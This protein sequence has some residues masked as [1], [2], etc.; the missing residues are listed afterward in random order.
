M[1]IGVEL[2][3]GEIG[4][5]L[6]AVTMVTAGLI[7]GYGVRRFGLGR[8]LARFLA[9]SAVVA[10]V[11]TV[12]AVPIIILYYG[13]DAGRGADGL[14]ATIA[15]P[16]ANPWLT[17]SSVN[18]PVSLVDKILTGAVAFAGARLI[19][20]RASAAEASMPVDPPI[21]LQRESRRGR[22]NYTPKR[23][24]SS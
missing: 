17:I 2:A 12:L 1:F 23:D 16:G 18:L 11:T 9:L 20:H 8:T 10:V 13:G 21:A 19:G 7:W 22:I 6:F 3:K 14:A 15:V 4:D 24:S 5:A